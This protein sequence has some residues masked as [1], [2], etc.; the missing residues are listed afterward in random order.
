MKTLR[1]QLKQ[2]KLVG[3]TNGLSII[4]NVEHGHGDGIG[5]QDIPANLTNKDEDFV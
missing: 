1:T 4:V 3:M 2:E 5:T